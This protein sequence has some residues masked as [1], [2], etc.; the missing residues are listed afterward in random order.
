M[1]TNILLSKRELQV[2]N[3]IA[4]EFTIKEIASELHISDHTVISHRK[5]ILDKLQAKNTVGLVRR[6]FELKYL[7]IQENS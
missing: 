3:L 4:N 7:K 2:L 1:S 6:A 5:K